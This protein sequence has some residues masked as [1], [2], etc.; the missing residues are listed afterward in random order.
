MYCHAHIRYTAMFMFTCCH[1]HMLSCTH[2]ALLHTFCLLFT[3]IQTGRPRVR[4]AGQRPGQDEVRALILSRE[5]YDNICGHF[6]KS[7]SKIQLATP[8]D[9]FL[10]K[11]FISVC[12]Q[13]YLFLPHPPSL[14]STPPVL[15]YRRWNQCT[16]RTSLKMMQ[17]RCPI[18]IIVIYG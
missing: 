9:L 2:T 10:Q 6:H 4:G 1:V 7:L 8:Q 16:V 18:I 3:A 17:K 14:S 11:P 5:Q 15:S 12:R 13:L